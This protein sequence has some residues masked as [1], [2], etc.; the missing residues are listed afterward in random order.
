MSFFDSAIFDTA[1]F[2]ADPAAS[3]G[4]PKARV[5]GVWAWRSIAGT[6]SDTIDYRKQEGRGA[7]NIS[8]ATEQ[9]DFELVVTFDPASGLSSILDGAVR[10]DAL[11]LRSGAR[12]AGEVDVSGPTTANCAFAAGILPSDR[13]EVQATFTPTDGAP[14]VVSASLWIVKP[15]A[16]A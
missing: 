13:Y 6:V 5:L 12:T 16:A 9:L 14:R 4:N 11:N 1:S 3:T 15:G 7:M 10:V 8:Y 2:D